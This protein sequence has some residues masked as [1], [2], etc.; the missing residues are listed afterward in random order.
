VP[1]SFEAQETNLPGRFNVTLTFRSIWLS[2][3]FELAAAPEFLSQ[4]DECV[5]NHPGAIRAQRIQP[6]PIEDVL[7]LWGATRSTREK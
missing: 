6:D 4:S 3:Y 7:K 2:G 1:S 5:G